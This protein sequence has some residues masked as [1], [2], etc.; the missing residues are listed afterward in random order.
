M[1]RRIPESIAES[2]LRDSK[3]R[4]LYVEGV[5]DKIF[6]EYFL[7][8]MFTPNFKIFVVDEAV[9]SPSCENG[10]RGRLQQLA[11]VLSKK[12]ANNI[13]VLLDSDFD[14]LRD[15]KN[16]NIIYTEFSDIEGHSIN[17]NALDKLLRIGY[18]RNTRI[19]KALHSKIL[20]I[21]ADIGLLRYVSH[22]YKLNLSINDTKKNKCISIESGLPMM[23]FNKYVSNV[24]NNTCPKGATSEQVLRWIAEERLRFKGIPVKNRIRGKDYHEVLLIYGKKSGFAWSDPASTIMATIETNE[25]LNTVHMKKIEAFIRSS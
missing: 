10:C 20:E 18:G 3:R 15:D 22:K 13:M 14:F 25:V 7:E 5:F 11:D 19:S 9:E 4:E 17:D 24:I 8:K 2:A 23:D 1:L 12:K 21:S 6:I 16:T